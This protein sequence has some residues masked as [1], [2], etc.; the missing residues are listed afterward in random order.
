MST[1]QQFTEDLVA[2]VPDF[3][4][5]IRVNVVGNDED[6]HIID[7]VVNPSDGIVRVMVESGEDVTVDPP[8]QPAEVAQPFATQA[9]D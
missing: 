5:P 9:E 8:V 4:M 6:L 2:I 3:D 1:V 7:I